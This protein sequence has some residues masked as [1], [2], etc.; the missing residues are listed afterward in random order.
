V[1]LRFMRLAC[2]VGTEE[3]YA[4][5]WQIGAVN[6]PNLVHLEF[7]LRNEIIR[8]PNL[9]SSDFANSISC[10]VS[11]YNRI[12]LSVSIWILNALLRIVKI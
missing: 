2:T 8:Y 7:F 9:H 5:T 10:L 3:A 1:L 12:K 4:A 6:H 11:E